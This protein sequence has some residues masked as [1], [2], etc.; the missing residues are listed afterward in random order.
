MSAEALER[1]EE[2]HMET[3]L[4]K[5]VRIK[6]LLLA[7]VFSLSIVMPVVATA[8]ELYDYAPANEVEV[9]APANDTGEAPANEAPTNDA[10]A[11]DAGEAPTN[12]APV[13]DAPANDAATKAG[14]EKVEVVG[15]DEAAEKVAAEA[16]VATGA[17]IEAA[18]QDITAFNA[19]GAS[20]S[21]SAFTMQSNDWTLPNQ[22]LETTVPSPGNTITIYVG[23]TIGIRHLASADFPVVDPG[24]VPPTM[25]ANILPSTT[26]WGNFTP[27]WGG[28]WQT[29]NPAWPSINPGTLEG[30]PGNPNPHTLP[31]K[32]SSDTA[33]TFSI[34]YDLTRWNGNQPYA[35]HPVLDSATFT[36]VVVEPDPGTPTFTF[37]FFDQGDN[38]LTPSPGAPV[39]KRDI[40]MGEFFGLYYNLTHT[41]ALENERAIVRALVEGP[42]GSTINLFLGESGSWVTDLAQCQW[43]HPTR[44][45]DIGSGC[46]LTQLGGI[47]NAPLKFASDTLGEHTITFFLQRYNPAQN[48]LQQEILATDSVTFNVVAP[49]FFEFVTFDPAAP[50]ELIPSIVY[51]NEFIGLRHILANLPQ[52]IQDTPAIIQV[53]ITGPDGAVINLIYDKG[54]DW[55]IDLANTDWPQIGSGQLGGIST[56]DVLFRSDTAGVFTITYTLT[57]YD[58]AVDFA[59]QR[60]LSAGSTTITVVEPQVDPT[61]ITAFIELLFGITP[62]VDGDYDPDEVGMLVVEFSTF[63]YGENVYLAKVLDLIYQLT[64][65]AGEGYGAPMFTI[66]V[67]EDDVWTEIRLPGVEYLTWEQVFLGFNDHFQ[68]Y[69][70]FMTVFFP[71]L[72]TQPVPCDVCD[73]YPCV[74][75]RPPVPCDVCDEYP[76]VCRTEAAEICEECGRYP[77]ECRTEAAE[78]PDPRDRRPATGPK[79][80][81]TNSFFAQMAVMAFV[82]MTIAITGLIRTREQS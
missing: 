32:F 62:G 13:N 43:K 78:R 22:A 48:P 56:A 3:R 46:P 44:G 8:V 66:W 20:I 30:V 63:V 65:F 82:V 14:D 1:R 68:D 26:T 47:R 53:T 21:F 17:E 54:G 34:T 19:F 37:S 50:T 36:I 23:E 74:C 75:P 64:G 40:L 70:I 24:H 73:E 45:S 25:R 72:E 29:F 16:V 67:F 42:D 35:Q 27:A 33:G 80:G 81:D 11:N 79:T 31:M 58:N 60:I 55:E 7:L 49:N 39:E 59:D 6:A 61:P 51:T 57:A 41:G 71:M 9:T 10:P 69:E 5:S 4:K 38:W 2:N 12:D 77:C 28:A 52:N 15:G 18:Y 76:C